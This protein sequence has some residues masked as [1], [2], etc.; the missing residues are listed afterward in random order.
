MERRLSSS[1]AERKE[2]QSKCEKKVE[3]WDKQFTRLDHEIIQGLNEIKVQIAKLEG[4]N[5]LAKELAQSIRKLAP[6][7]KKEQQ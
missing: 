4:G 1:E 3:N 6:R 7:S 5:E 2:C